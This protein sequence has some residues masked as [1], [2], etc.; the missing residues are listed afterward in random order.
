[1]DTIHLD[2]ELLPE[3]DYED[4]YVAVTVG[5]GDE[6]WES[7]VGSNSQVV[8]GYLGTRRASNVEEFKLRMP[9]ITFF[10]ENAVCELILFREDA[11]LVATNLSRGLKTY[12]RG[13]I[14]LL[15]KREE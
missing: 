9:L 1:V 2:L 8:V 11:K 13:Q 10:A 5:I 14:E 7:K 12:T 15:Q 6:I 3:L 4:A